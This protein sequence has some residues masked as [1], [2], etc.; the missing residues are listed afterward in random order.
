MSQV[1]KPSADTT[2]R[3]AFLGVLS[4]AALSLA[5]WHAGLSSQPQV[6]QPVAQPVPFSHKHHVGEVGLDCRY[7]HTSVE[8]SSF[9]GLPPTTTCMTCHSQLFQ[10]APMLAPIRASLTEHR[11]IHWRRV[12]QL[13]DFVYFNHRIHVHKGVGCSTCHG[14]VDRMPLTWRAA[15]LTMG[16]CLDCHRDP[17][18]YLRPRDQVLAMDWQPPP[19]QRDRG[20]RL[21]A[22]YAIH[23]A[24]LSDCSVCHR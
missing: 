18:R 14:R 17:E 11:P 10:T 6:G 21:A 4:F 8:D 15:P 1:F 12:H 3:V 20:K 23:P 22:R 5:A 24:R 16:W 9:A 13:P 19:D 2:L 7:C